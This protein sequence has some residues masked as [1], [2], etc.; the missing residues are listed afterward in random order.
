MA[1]RLYTWNSFSS[2]RAGSRNRYPLEQH[3]LTESRQGDAPKNSDT[4]P[5]TDLGNSSEILPAIKGIEA[6]IRDLI[7]EEDKIEAD[8]QRNQEGRD[9]EAQESMAKWARWM[10]WATLG[11]AAVTIV[12]LVLIGFTLNYTKKAAEHTEG[13][14][15]QA[16]RATIAAED[17]VIATRDIGEK[18]VRAYL[19]VKSVTLTIGEDGDSVGATLSIA[20]A[21]Q[22]P[23]I[24]CSALVTVETDN[25]GAAM[26]RVPLPN[27]AANSETTRTLK[28]AP[29]DTFVLIGVKRFTASVAIEAKDVF[30]KAIGATSMR[31]IYDKRGVNIGGS[32]ELEDAEG[33]L[34]D[35][36]VKLLASGKGRFGPNKHEGGK[37][38]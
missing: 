12:G 34:P 10:F 2:I 36:A 21:G 37:D 22:S 7:A 30:G 9:L 11:T 6:A 24:E 14:L 38:S 23:A 1:V 32:Y 28:P 31:T 16:E 5:Q 19:H 25:R 17:A 18:Q 33:Y 27:I 8:R 20:N 13:M 26:L 35:A 29:R 15:R 3:P 4:S